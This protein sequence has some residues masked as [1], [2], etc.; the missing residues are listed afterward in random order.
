MGEIALVEAV[1]P[2]SMPK[3]IVVDKIL[4]LCISYY[5]LNLQ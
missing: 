5:G 1:S 4:F 3:I 2:I